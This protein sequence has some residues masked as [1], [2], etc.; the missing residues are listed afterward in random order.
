MIAVTTFYIRRYP[1]PIDVQGSHAV[2]LDVGGDGPRQRLAGQHDGLPGGLQ[3]SSALRK[4]LPRDPPEHPQ[5]PDGVPNLEPRVLQGAPEPVMGA[6]AP[7]GQQVPA[8]LQ[9][10]QGG[11]S[12]ALGPDLSGP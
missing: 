3:A 12:P 4:P 11:L 2:R 6:G 7:E 1:A 10:A 8:G 9:D 5:E